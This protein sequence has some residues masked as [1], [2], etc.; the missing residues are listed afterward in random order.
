MRFR[1]LYKTSVKVLFTLVFLMLA[2]S[3]LL[4]VFRMAELFGFVSL[5]LGMEIVTLV[6][7][8]FLLAVAIVAVCTTGYKLDEKGVTFRLLFVKIFTPLE[9]ISAFEYSKKGK[10]ACVYH[11]VKQDEEAEEEI[12]QMAINIAPEKYAEFAKKLKELKNTVVVLPYDEL[13]KD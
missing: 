2:T 13:N 1:L 7:T 12:A 4:T 8:L 10:L 9:N 11:T 5:S 6:V 3:L